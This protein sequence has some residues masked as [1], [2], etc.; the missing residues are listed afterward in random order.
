MPGLT[1]KLDSL[2]FFLLLLLVLLAPLPLASNREWSWTLIA[3]LTGLLTLAWVLI[4]VIA[5][6]PVFN[7]LHPLIPILFLLTVAWAWVQ[8]ANWVP[9]N[10]KHPVWALAA[11]SLDVHMAGA[12]SLAP[13]ET[14]TAIMRLLSY[15]LVFFL[16]FQ[17][18]RNRV[19]ARSS[20]RWIF[21]AGVVYSVYGLLSYFG[22]LR[23]FMWYQDDA[24]GRDVRAT[25]VNR[26]HFA[27]WVGLCLVCAIGVFFDHMFRTPV[28]PMMVLRARQERFDAFM[29]PAWIPLAGMILLVSALV[30][31][32][33]R[34]GFVSA[35]FGGLVLLLLIDRKQGRV[36]NRTRLIAISALLVSAV[37]FFISS[38]VLLRRIDQTDLGTEGRVLI[39]QQ[40]SRAIVDNPLLGFG[41]GTFEDGF[42]LYRG[43]DITRLVDYAHNTYL[44]NMFELGIPFALCLMGAVL[45]LA[46]TSLKG[47]ARR[48]R[49][50]VYP[51]VGVAA[52]VLVAIHATVDFSLQIPAVAMLYAF[53]MG[54]A[55][56]Q[57]YSSL[58]GRH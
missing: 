44:E 45:G 41:Y 56:A 36:S 7:R 10:W 21:A 1:N 33:S 6:R 16:A 24:F 40:V 58:G 20:L 57:S 17:L 50:W 12:I 14:I 32:H 37:A 47:L 3:F 48:Q 35:F 27:T 38:E 52:S 25:F 43:E 55:C 8:T 18:G 5:R 34:G 30:S 46:L 19:P 51:A 23:E 4:T 29:A 49:D 22:V 9:E 54:V 26:N 39:F 13:T 31:S 15:G 53:I 2:L 28:N 42:R 11:E